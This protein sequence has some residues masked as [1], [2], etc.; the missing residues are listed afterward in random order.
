MSNVRVVIEF[1]KI[2]L[3]LLVLLVLSKSRYHLV[4]RMVLVKAS[5][6]W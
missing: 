2:A 3:L 1:Q 5:A 4:T 6:E